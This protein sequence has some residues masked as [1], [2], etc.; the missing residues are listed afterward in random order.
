MKMMQNDDY[1]SALA[2]LVKDVEI[3]ERVL[4]AIETMVYELYGTNETSMIETK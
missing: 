2:L 1:K 4:E 3:S